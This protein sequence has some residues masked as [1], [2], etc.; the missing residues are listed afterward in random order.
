MRSLKE[1]CGARQ[2]LRL[3]WLNSEGKTV[4]IDSQSTLHQWIDDGWCCHPLALH[5]LDEATATSDALDL[6]DKASML[7]EQYDVDQNGQI[8]LAELSNLLQSMSLTNLGVSEEMV[9][10]FVE[11]EFKLAGNVEVTVVR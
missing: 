3:L 6:A 5:V 4:V 10:H 8:D 11:R 9:S 1:Q 7:F 2:K